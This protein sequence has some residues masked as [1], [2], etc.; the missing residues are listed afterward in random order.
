M[1]CNH[2]DS[3]RFVIVRAFKERDVKAKNVA[4]SEVSGMPVAV[5]PELKCVIAAPIR[6]FNDPQCKPLGTI[7]F[8]SNRTLEEVHFEGKRAQEIC[9]VYASSIYDLLKD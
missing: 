4:P 5:W 2:P 1:P 8:D 7:N 3:N 9:R 6:D